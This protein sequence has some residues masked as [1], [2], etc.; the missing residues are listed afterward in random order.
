M[1]CGNLSRHI[2]GPRHR[3]SIGV[4]AV[5]MIAGVRFGD[6]FSGDGA[7]VCGHGQWVSV[8]EVD[9]AGDAKA[10]LELSPAPHIEIYIA[11]DLGLLD[12]TPRNSRAALTSLRA[13]WN[14]DFLGREISVSQ[15]GSDPCV[16]VDLDLLYD[17]EELCG[18]KFANVLENYLA[19]ESL[20]VAGPI[21]ALR[22]HT[23]VC[24]LENSGV[25]DLLPTDTG[26]DSREPRNDNARTCGH[27]SGDDGHPSIPEPLQQ[28]K[29]YK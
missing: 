21:N 17:A 26:K 15:L 6:C 3:R 2:H 5:L 28:R 11:I 7:R 22:L 1:F 23:H 4:V 18:R 12:L 29:N 27:C 9:V 25:R 19:D 8:A 24:S 10:V 20:S 13:D 16:V 14:Y